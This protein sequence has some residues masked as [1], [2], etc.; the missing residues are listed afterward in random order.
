[1]LNEI[2]MRLNGVFEHHEGH[3]ETV[4]DALERWKAK[5]DLEKQ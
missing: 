1:M 2:M 5:G 4:F 3:Y